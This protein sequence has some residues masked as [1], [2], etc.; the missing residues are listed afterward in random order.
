M[1]LLSIQIGSLKPIIIKDVSLRNF[2]F[3]FHV[4]NDIKVSIDLYYELLL[5][6]QL[7]NY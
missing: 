6:N 7:I 5:T 3:I 1:S 2:H 4:H